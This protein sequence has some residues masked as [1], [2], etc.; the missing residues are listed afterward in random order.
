M[1]EGEAGLGL[2]QLVEVVQAH[3]VGR[4]KV[5]LRVLVPL[6]A[7]PDL[8]VQLGRGQR[9]QEGRVG[10]RDAHAVLWG[11]TGWGMGLLPKHERE[12]REV[13]V[14]RGRVRRSRTE[15]RF[16]RQEGERLMR[17]RVLNDVLIWGSMFKTEAC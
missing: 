11:R 13:A 14:T 10:R 3:H 7:A 6:P 2:S 16:P 8:V 5:A 4:L 15:M 17:T 1:C 12:R 9:R